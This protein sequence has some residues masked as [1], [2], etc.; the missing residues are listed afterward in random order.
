MTQQDPFQNIFGQ[1][2]RKIKSPLPN[3][4]LARLS[5]QAREGDVVEANKLL[6]ANQLNES[7]AESLYAD[8]C[9]GLIVTAS[10]ENKS[11]QDALRTSGFW[12]RQKT[13]TVYAQKERH[14]IKSGDYA[15][16][17]LPIKKSA[18]DNTAPLCSA[19]QKAQ[20]KHH[21]GE[22]VFSAN[23]LSYAQTETLFQE[24]QH[25]L[26]R[27][28]NPGDKISEF[29][30]EAALNKAVI[31]LLIDKVRE[32]PGQALISLSISHHKHTPWIRLR[33]NLY[34]GAGIRSLDDISDEQ[35]KLF[36]DKL[37]FQPAYSSAWNQLEETVYET[38]GPKQAG[39]FICRALISRI[40]VRPSKAERNQRAWLNN[41]KKIRKKQF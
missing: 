2:G 37:F 13:Y 22:K 39:K 15:F 18:F 41:E 27:N 17:G 24:A 1:R 31:T 28:N 40:V 26:I 19:C 8:I 6:R 36:L 30:A 29:A 34:V 7:E 21:Q 35:L 23:I 3:I 5:S 10:Q 38:P 4:K 9:L 11:W 12:S 16:C 32:N 20:N 14:L 25:V 33:R